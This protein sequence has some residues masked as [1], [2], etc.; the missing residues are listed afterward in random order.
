[1]VLDIT[2]NKQQLNALQWTA[3]CKQQ[4]DAWKKHIR[5]VDIKQLIS[6]K[7]HGVSLEH[8]HYTSTSIDA[9]HFN[10]QKHQ[11]TVH[12]ALT[13]A[14]TGTQNNWNYRSMINSAVIWSTKQARTRQEHVTS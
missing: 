9:R 12:S 13:H 8:M 5:H 11:S 1:V 7:W 14:N 3:E 4:R 10:M 2:V 6:T